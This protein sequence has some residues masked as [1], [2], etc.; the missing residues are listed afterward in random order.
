MTKTTTNRE[1]QDMKNKKYSAATLGRLPS[2]TKPRREPSAEAKKQM[3]TNFD[4]FAALVSS[5]LTV[6]AVNN[7]NEH[8]DTTVIYD[9]VKMTSTEARDLA[10]KNGVAKLWFLPRDKWI[11]GLLTIVSLPN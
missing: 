7:G 5:G 9:G 4:K 10:K 2:K 11:D 8:S 1:V 6:R 3:A